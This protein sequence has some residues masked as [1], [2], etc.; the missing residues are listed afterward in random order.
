MKTA[1]FLAGAVAG[2][3][4]GTRAG[5]ERYQQLVDGA[6]R[7]G[8]KPSVQQAKTNLGDLVSKSIDTA[9]AK[10]GSATDKVT[11]NL[12]ASGPSESPAVTT[13]PA[14]RKTAPPVGTATPTTP[15]MTSG[16]EQQA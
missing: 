6:R 7:L 9:N 12:N 15:P 5:R 14:P 3:V 10:I 4:L 8:N 13:P 16:R 2:Y 1:T 11:A